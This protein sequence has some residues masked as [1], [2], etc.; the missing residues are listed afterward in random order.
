[1]I[2]VKYSFNCF[3]FKYTSIDSKSYF[4]SLYMLL[5]L[6]VLF[7]SNNSIAEGDAFKRLRI[8]T[9]TNNNYQPSWMINRCHGQQFGLGHWL[10]SF[11]VGVGAWY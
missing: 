6:E 4:A 11:I 1:M 9:D 2:L 10:G 8:D 3:A 5:M 7:E